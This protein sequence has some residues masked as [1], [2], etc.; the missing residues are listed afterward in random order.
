MFTILPR[1]TEKNESFMN[2]FYESGLIL[3]FVDLA[4]LVGCWVFFC[5]FI[6]LFVF[7]FSYVI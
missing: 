3:Y 6:C 2:R 4:G 7:F 1:M 5:C